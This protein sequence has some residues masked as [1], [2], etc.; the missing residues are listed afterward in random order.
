MTQTDLRV[1][2]MKEMGAWPPLYVYSDV[3]TSTVEEYV[4][5][6]EERVIKQ[7]L[8]I[9]ESQ[10]FSDEGEIKKEKD[11]ETVYLDL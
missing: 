7:R 10:L 6:L 8:K 4:A 1:E 3:K 11:S 2:Y 5:W 9:L